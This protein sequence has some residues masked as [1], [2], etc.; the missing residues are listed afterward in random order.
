MCPWDVPGLNLVSD[1][2]ALFYQGQGARE[3]I[4][5]RRRSD[6]FV[7][8]RWGLWTAQVTSP[9]R[10]VSKA[11]DWQCFCRVGR[12]AISIW[13]WKI[14]SWQK[15]QDRKFPVLFSTLGDTGLQGR[16]R[17]GRRER[18]GRGCECEQVGQNDRPALRWLTVKDR[19]KGRRLFFL[20]CSRRRLLKKP[21]ERG[22]PFLEMNSKH[23]NT[24][25]QPFQHRMAQEQEHSLP[26]RD[27]QRGENELY[28]ARQRL[29]FVTSDWG[30]PSMP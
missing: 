25:K 16:G 23:S 9:R 24:R 13:I 26:R 20:K 28:R 8:T 30:L 10:G 15:Q 7:L 3:L 29:C 21:T 17:Q 4:K 22:R 18:R 14:T 1:V 27:W 12:E 19:R 2:I 5:G 11:S 6:T